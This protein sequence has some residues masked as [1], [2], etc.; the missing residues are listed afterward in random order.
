M[1]NFI[2]GTP[3]D[4][5]PIWDNQRYLIFWGKCLPGSFEIPLSP[6]PFDTT[7]FYK[8]ALTQNNMLA[9]LCKLVLLKMSY[10]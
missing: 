5:F 3:Q 2:S 8:F 1:S 6:T 9:H 10:E 4:N 7:V